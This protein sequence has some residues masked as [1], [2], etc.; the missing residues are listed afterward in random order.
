MRAVAKEA[1]CTIGMINHWF[2]SRD[3]L[4][5][6]T[7]NRLIELELADAVKIA[8]DQSTYFDAASQF[9]PVDERRRDAA[10]VWVAFYAMVLSDETYIEL[11][12]TRCH[13]VRKAIVKGLR[14]IAPLASCHDIADRILVL[15]DGIAINA[16]LDP[17]RWTRAKQRAVL[18]EGIEDAFLRNR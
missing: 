13:E 10:K 16:L 6:K 7:F 1:D 14:D 18:Q 12:T 11:R 15:V 4:I 9:L 5:E 17:K 2:S 8:A 3:D